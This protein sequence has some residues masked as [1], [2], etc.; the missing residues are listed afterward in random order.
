VKLVVALGILLVAGVLAGSAGAASRYCSPTGDYCTSTTRQSGAVF[1]RLTTFSFSGRLRICV[2]DP[3][4]RRVCRTF[5]LRRHGGTWQVSVRWHR[6]YPNGGPG[7]YRVEFLT[8]GTRL[9]PVL[10]FRLR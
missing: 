6:R 4:S 8:G 7:R 2:T 5:T 1:L 3:R 10:D 9:G